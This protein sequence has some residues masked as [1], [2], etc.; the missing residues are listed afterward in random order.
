ME[1]EAPFNPRVGIIGSGSWAT[2]IASLLTWHDLPGHP[3]VNWWIRRKESLDQMARTGHNPHYLR[4]L[5]LKRDR[6]ALSTNLREVVDKSDILILAIPSA[7]LDGVLESLPLPDL[8][9]KV[10]FSAIKGLISED[11]H[12]PARY[13]HKV[14]GVPYDRI[15]LISGPSHAEEVAREQWTYLTLASP[16]VTVAERLAN[17]M[18]NPWLHIRCNDDLFGIELAAVLKNVYALASGVSHGL[19]L[20]DNFIAVLIASALS[21]TERF[22]NAV[23]DTARDLSSSAYLGD[24]LVTAYSPHSRNRTLG[25]MVGKGY[26]VQGALMEMGMVAEGYRSALGIHSINRKFGVDMPV[27]DAVYRIFHEQVAPSIEMRILS[28]HIH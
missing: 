15:G 4:S 2:A 8:E 23:N 5:T 18:A 7:H 19:G 21:E 27:A 16:D 1:S 24:L 25:T 22:L 20:G 11:H 10:V 12:I 3:P 17:R 13:L 9:N 6:L 26:S 14:M 28:E